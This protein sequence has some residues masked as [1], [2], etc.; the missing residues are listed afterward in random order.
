MVQTR[1]SENLGEPWQFKLEASPLIGEMANR[2]LPL[3]QI[4][5]LAPIGPA[6]RDIIIS[7]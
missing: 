6:R 4:P 1:I 5:V 2:E 7:D 3:I